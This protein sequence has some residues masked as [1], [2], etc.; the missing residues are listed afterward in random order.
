MSSPYAVAVDN[1]G[2]FYIADTGNNCIRKVNSAGIITTV[3]GVCNPSLSQ[4]SYS[5]D[6]GPATTA[7]LNGPHGVAADSA[8]NIFTADTNNHRIRKVSADGI[9]TTIAGNGAELPTQTGESGWVPTGNLVT[10]RTEHTATLLQNGKVLVVGGGVGAGDDHS[11]ELYDPVTRT[12][13]LT[14]R[15]TYNRQ[16]HT[17]TLLPDGRVLV[18]GGIFIPIENPSAELYDPVSGTWSNTGSPLGRAGHSATLLPNG[19]VLI[20]GGFE[21][22]SEDSSPLTSAE[23]YDPVT[24]KWSFTGSLNVGRSGSTMTLLQ[25]GRVLIAGGRY[26]IDDHQTWLV[27]SSAEIYNPATG[28]WSATGNLKTSRYNHRAILLRNGKVLVR[29]GSGEGS[30]DVAEL[31]DP[32]TGTW[33]FIG[34]G[35]A[36]PNPTL[37]GTLT[38]LPDDR[39]LAVGGYVSDFVPP[40]IFNFLSIDS[41]ELY[42]PERAT[43]TSARNPNVPRYAHTATLLRNGEVLIV[44]GQSHSYNILGTAELYVP[45]AAPVRIDPSFTGSWFD[46]SQSGQGLMLEVLSDNRLLAL[47]FTF[48][49]EGQQ[50]WFG[51]IGTYSGNSATISDVALPTGGRWIP[52]FDPSAVV[53]EPWGKLTFTFTDCNHGLIEFISPTGYGAG[54][55]NLLRLTLPD[56]QSCP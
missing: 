47:W 17:A 35:T 38:L 2:N 30:V 16:G 11:A 22:G 42:D 8:G 21:R 51:G 10:P 12:W 49:P 28:K 25:D 27:A 53:R 20:A 40:D 45:S 41:A 14:P 18:A 15:L 48:S 44:G 52:N 37:F 39:V 3:A 54:S 4:A 43:W 55:M 34:T 46:P 56:G 36:T 33:T 7:R 6:G 32:T 50:S 9:I 29:G 31:Y 19:K 24:G 1:T 13:S 5:G 26:A 23:L